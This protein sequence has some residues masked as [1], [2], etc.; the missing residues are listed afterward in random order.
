MRSLRLL[1]AGW[2]SL[3][4]ECAMSGAAQFAGG[5]VKPGAF[6]FESLQIRIAEMGAIDDTTK[7]RRG[8]P[9]SK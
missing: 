9:E 7:V 3:T 1:V 2:L 4:A 8:R 5:Q 6:K